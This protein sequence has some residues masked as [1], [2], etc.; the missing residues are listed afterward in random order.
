LN[1]ADLSN[2]HEA[3]LAAAAHGDVVTLRAM[4]SMHVNVNF[5]QN[6]T[7]PLHRAVESGNPEAVRIL[8]EHGAKDSVRDAEGKTPL[9]IV[10]EKRAAGGDDHTFLISQMFLLKK[11][12]QK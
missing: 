10:L 6:G 7:T 8:I 4:L 2:L 1:E 5:L 11:V 12:D 9:E 3:L